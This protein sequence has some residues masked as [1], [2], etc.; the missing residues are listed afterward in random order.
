MWKKHKKSIPL[1]SFLEENSTR[2]SFSEEKED[3]Q[4]N[5][6]TAEVSNDLVP[7]TIFFKFK[8]KKKKDEERISILFSL[9]FQ[10]AGKYGI[11]QLFNSWYKLIW[12]LENGENTS[13]L[14]PEINRSIVTFLPKL[15][16]NILNEDFWEHFKRFGEEICNYKRQEESEVE[17]FKTILMQLNSVDEYFQRVTKNE[18][19]RNILL[20]YV[21]KKGVT[22]SNHHFIQSLR[23]IKQ[24][25]DLQKERICFKNERNFVAI[26]GKTKKEGIGRFIGKKGVH[27]KFINKNFKVFYNVDTGSKR[28]KAKE[29]IITVA[30]NIEVVEKVIDY[31][32]KKRIFSLSEKKEKK[33][34]TF[35]QYCN[36][37]GFDYRIYDPVNQI[38]KKQNDSKVIS[39]GN[40]GFIQENNWEKI[41]CILQTFKRVLKKM[42]MQTES[43][44][45]SP[46]F[47]TE[48]KPNIKKIINHTGLYVPNGIHIV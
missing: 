34:V 16:M 27:F 1:R 33:D 28:R 21:E 37:F 10:I 14:P 30:G 12:I 41:K 23:H 45:F 48:S 13:V 11:F 32:Q 29:A 6:R 40:F 36:F 24:N 46:Q 7:E 8:E 5:W 42:H 26:F 43:H 9:F 15:E 44:S 47:S 18:I 39:Y 38:L 25:K 4:E 3:V 17:K 31:F 19:A 2:I 20:E 35:D 22:L